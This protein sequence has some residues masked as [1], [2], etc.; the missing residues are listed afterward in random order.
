VEALLPWVRGENDARAALAR[1]QIRG[2]EALKPVGLLS[3]G[4]RA[5]I[6]LA[7]LTARQCNLLLLDEPL[8]HLDAPSR[9]RFEEALAQFEGAVLAVV[10][11]RTF[12]ERF[13]GEVWRVEGAT[14]RVVSFSP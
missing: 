12:I 7:L 10:H 8:N 3:H 9:D 5:R 2:D 13:A 1:C 11:D 6:L 4:Q 14:I